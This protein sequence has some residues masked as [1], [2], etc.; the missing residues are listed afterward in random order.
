MLFSERTEIGV[1]AFALVAHEAYRGM[2]PNAGAKKEQ[3]SHRR[4]P[5]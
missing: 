3:V 1:V 5:L 2:L 4:S